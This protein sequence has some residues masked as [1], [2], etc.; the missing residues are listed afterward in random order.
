L[1]TATLIFLLIS[2]DF[3]ASDYCYG[4]EM[5]RA[6]Q[7]HEAKEAHVLP[8]LLRPCDWQSAPFASLAIL[9]AGQKPITTWSDQDAA[10]TDVVTSIRQVLHG[11]PLSERSLPRSFDA[12]IWNVPFARNPFFTGRDVLL[13]QLHAQLHSTQAA[14]ISQPQA[15]SGLIVMRHSMTWREVYVKLSPIFLIKKIR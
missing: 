7:L 10:W 15:I 14:A 8:I 12:T 1:N 9:P 4:I 13:E 11:R 6:L 5:R 2:S 3:L